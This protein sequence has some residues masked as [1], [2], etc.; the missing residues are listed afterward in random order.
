[1]K[2]GGSVFGEGWQRRAMKLRNKLGVLTRNRLGLM[3]HRICRRIQPRLMAITISALSKILGVSEPYADIG[4]GRHRPASTALAGAGETGW[5]FEI[6]QDQSSSQ[7]NQTLTA[8]GGKISFGTAQCCNCNVESAPS[9]DPLTALRK[10]CQ[11][12]LGKWRQALPRTDQFLRLRRGIAEWSRC[13]RRSR[14]P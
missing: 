12:H 4:A 9:L 6:R 1:V 2:A 3:K 11:D 8:F 13:P 14:S 7:V 5:R 10:R